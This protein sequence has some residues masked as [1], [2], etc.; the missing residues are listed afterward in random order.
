MAYN[1]VCLAYNSL[2]QQFELGTAESFWFQLDSI[3]ESVV[4][5]QF[6]WE[7]ALLK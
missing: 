2:G 5:C 6:I 7:P 3:S 1:S 4:T